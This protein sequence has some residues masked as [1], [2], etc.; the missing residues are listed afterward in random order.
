MS[1]R[2]EDQSLWRIA[3]HAKP[4]LHAREAHVWRAALTQ[5]EA[6]F[7]KLQASLSSDELER[8]SRFQFE[9]HRRR[10]VLAR[11]ALRDVLSRYLGLA[12]NQITFA[13]EARGKPRLADAINSDNL[14]FNLTHAEELAL[15][16]VTH[17]RMLGVDVEHVHPMEDAEQI[18]RRFF[19]PREA[20]QF[21]ALP[22]EQKLIAF[23]HCWTRKE[24]FIKA[25]GEGLSHPLHQFEVSFLPGELPAVLCTRPDPREAAR[26]SMFAFEPAQDYIAAL[27]VAGKDLALK[28]W[29]WD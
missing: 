10:F 29:Q 1:A 18:A 27:I 21:C 14:C 15:C 12:A 2:L 25:L 11:G 5:P 28:Y 26:W 7:Q 17:G 20:E 8:A 9:K 16:A 13:Y 24:A 3:P 4:E 23:F 22:L 19:S 6:V